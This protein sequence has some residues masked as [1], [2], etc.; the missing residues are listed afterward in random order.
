MLANITGKILVLLLFIP[1]AI[2]RAFYEGALGFWYGLSVEW[3]D[4]VRLMTTR[5]EKW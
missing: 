2:A 1:I 3:E 4:F 5:I